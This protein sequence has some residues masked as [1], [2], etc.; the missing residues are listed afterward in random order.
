[1]QWNERRRRDDAPLGLAS[2]VGIAVATTVGAGVFVTTGFLAQS[3]GPASI[4][5]AWL[6]GSAIALAGARA[7]AALAELVPRSGGEYRYLSDLVH[8]ALGFLAGWASLLVGFSAPVAIDALAAA[9]YAGTLVP[10]QDPRLLASGLIAALTALHTLGRR[11]SRWTQDLL[12][13]A[14]ASLLV[15]F[16]AVGLALGRNRWPSWTPRDERPALPALFGSLLYI[17]Y[18]FSGWNTAVYAASEFRDPKRTVRAAVLVGCALVAALY[19]AINWIFVANLTPERAAAV[20]SREAA[21]ITLGHLVI[22]DLLGESGGKA[23]S[24]LAVAVF[25]S[26]ASAMMFAGPRVYAAMARDGFL[27]APLAGD[28]GRPP[29]GSIVLQG[30]LATLLVQT[31]ELRQVLENAGAI[32]TLF[33]ALAVL[34]LFRVALARDGRSRPAAGALVAST[35]FAG[36]SSLVLYFAFRDSARLLLW[37]ACV[38][39]AGLLAYFLTV[40]R[41][42][43]STGK[44]GSRTP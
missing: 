1:M 37:I 14:K 29:A 11:S 23:M 10:V 24:I 28:E 18:A 17:A 15:G 7:Y 30:A 36:S 8:P 21:R 16:V 43:R 3:M 40:S 2:G 33:S 19:L 41:R 31:H 13:L 27:P 38:A 44:A 35:F 20:V 6:A 34:A 22:R 32:L 39:G 5:L 12:A 4:L 9:S 26:A 25:L 42:A